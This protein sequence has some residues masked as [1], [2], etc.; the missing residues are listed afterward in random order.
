MSYIC[1]SL[2]SPG[3]ARYAIVSSVNNKG[4]GSF[5]HNLTSYFYFLP[6]PIGYTIGPRALDGMPIAE[7]FF[8]AALGRMDLRWKGNKKQHDV[9][10]KPS[11]GV[12]VPYLCVLRA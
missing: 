6:Y 9:A 11:N 3:L 10:E 4:F 5:S 1:F 12:I 2:N 8:L 7:A